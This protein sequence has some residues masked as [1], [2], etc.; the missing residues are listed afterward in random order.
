MSLAAV[1]AALSALLLPAA[2]LDL[3]P[4]P[5][6]RARFRLATSPHVRVEFREKGG[7]VTAFEVA[8]GGAP[9]DTYV[10][11]KASPAHTRALTDA[12]R[13][14]HS[15]GVTTK[16]AERAARLYGRWAETYSS[17]R[18]RGLRA[19]T[20]VRQR[21]AILRLAAP[22][23]GDLVLDVGCGSGDMVRLLR[24][25]VAEV[26]GVD[27]SPE[28]LAQARPLLDHAVAG[29]A[30]D[31]LLRRQFDLVLCCG[32]LDFVEDPGAVLRS[33]A[34][35]LAP[36]GRAVVAASGRTAIGAVYALVRALYGVRVTLYSASQLA[37]LATVSRLRCL[38]IGQIPGGSVAA[39]VRPAVAPGALSSPS[40]RDQTS[41]MC[42]GKG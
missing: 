41:G 34:R 4:L 25:T 31:L 38:Q 40:H 42:S 28:M 2:A 13:R 11:A 30:E 16:N 24:G 8:D 35:H 36:S 3:L 26:W 37:A 18:S 17:D 29:Y 7:A 12:P 10:R 5:T 32:V 20:L 27:A 21:Q 1:A 19:G 23:P 22:L 15:R 14:S 9:V 6:G 33:I 39:L